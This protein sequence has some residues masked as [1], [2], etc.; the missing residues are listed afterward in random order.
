MDT[1]W[2]AK[3][4]GKDENLKDCLI[5]GAIGAVTNTLFMAMGK[6]TNTVTKR[7]VKEVVKASTK[8]SLNDLASRAGKTTLRSILRGV[9]RAHLS[10]AVQTGINQGTVPMSLSQEKST[11]KVHKNRKKHLTNE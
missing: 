6:T 11:K 9:R 10:T 7:T 1:A 3:N 5:D 2:E 8:N 4:N